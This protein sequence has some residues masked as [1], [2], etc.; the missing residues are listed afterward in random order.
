MATMELG[1]MAMTLA[2][3]ALAFSLVVTVA[4]NVEVR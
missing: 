3:F 1:F 2:A 4:A